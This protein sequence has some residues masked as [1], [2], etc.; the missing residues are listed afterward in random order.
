M[1][2]F[3]FD[4]LT[5]EPTILATNRAKRVDQTGAVSSIKPEL[6]EKKEFVDIFAKGNEHLTPPTLY[7]DADN[8]NVRVFDN[9]FPLINNHEIVV[10][11]PFM[12][13]DIEDLPH[14]HNIKIIRAYINR[15]KHY[16]DQD[17]D[18]IIFNNRGGKAG[19]SIVH[20]HSQII[21]SRGFP[22]TIEKEKDSA[23]HYYNEHNIS[24]WTVA[25]NEAIEDKQRVILETSH[26]VLYV[27]S[28]CRWSYEMK[29]VPKVARANF[30]DISDEEIHDLAHVL[31]HAL[32]AYN[33][34][35]DRPDRNF[36]VHTSIH[37]PYHWHIG[38]LPHIKVFGALE[39]GAG[40]W[41][42]DKA[43]PEDAA[44]ELRA[45]LQWESSKS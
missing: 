30:G 39:L 21:S 20:P 4:P 34:L 12:D 14:E 45:V 2:H 6:K 11:S 40:I 8:W 13:K 43:T 1:S 16:Q 42:S 38:F 19:A 22:G 31:K 32:I 24:Y 10:H 41:V 3:I 33:N 44:S 37:E 28:A 35:F 25:I 26:F 27:P 23:L 7:Q 29:I 17:M 18:V 5:G 15:V 36:W 9:K